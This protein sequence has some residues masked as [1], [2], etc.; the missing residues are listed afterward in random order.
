M[1]EQTQGSFLTRVKAAKSVEP[2]RASATSRFCATSTARP[3]TPSAA[4]AY[5]D[6]AFVGIVTFDRQLPGGSTDT[7]TVPVV[8]A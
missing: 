2:G 5:R 1:P 3:A 7:M 4:A 8:G 6:M